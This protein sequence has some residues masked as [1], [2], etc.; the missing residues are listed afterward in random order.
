VADRAK[1]ACYKCNQRIDSYPCPHCKGG[2]ERP[3]YHSLYHTRQWKEL[4]SYHLQHNPLC[5]MCLDE[6]KVTASS[7]KHDLHV[8]HIIEHKGDLALFFDANNLRSLCA[9]HHN[10]RHAAQ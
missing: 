2:D 7:G 4:R 3:A 6:G 9:A 10:K 5:V 1:R 8:D